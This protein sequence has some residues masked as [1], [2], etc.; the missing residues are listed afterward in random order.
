MES[1]KISKNKKSPERFPENA[2]GDFYV[3]NGVCITCYAPEAEAP[4]LIDHSK[5][6]YGHCFFK[7]QPE[8]VEELELAINAMQVSCINGIRYGGKDENIL[9][10]L[11]ELGMENECDHAPAELEK[12]G[13]RTKVIFKYNGPI[14][15]LYK[16]LI[17]EIENFGKTNDRNVFD[18]RTNNR[19]FFEFT[20]RSG[21]PN[22]GVQ[23]FCYSHENESCRIE[24]RIERESRI[25]S[26]IK[27]GNILDNML[28]C[29][30]DVSNIVWYNIE[31][32]IY[33]NVLCY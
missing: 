23:F 13:V 14:K 10:K 26:V 4:N 25:H 31:G 22:T 21:W 11:Y 17:N 12:Y 19:D 20:Y 30:C 8:T 29:N 6:E 27:S 18:N 5:I 3:E 15:H 16:F 2:K 28:K 9:N 33:G 1:P 7:K 32:D 24:L